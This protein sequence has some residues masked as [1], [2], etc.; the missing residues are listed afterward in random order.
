[1][2]G[3]PGGTGG[4]AA[5]TVEVP[6]LDDLSYTAL[7]YDDDF[8]IATIDAQW[9]LV[10]YAEGAIDSTARPSPSGL[11]STAT[12]P[13]ALL[14]QPRESTVAGLRLDA[15][16]ADGEAFLMSVWCSQP[17]RSD[18]SNNS[19]WIG[20][21]WGDSTTDPAALPNHRLCWDGG[22]QPRVWLLES[23]T[24]AVVTIDNATTVPGSLNQFLCSR[25][26]DV[27]RCWWRSDPLGA[28]VPM[29]FIDLAIE[30]TY[31]RTWILITSPAAFGGGQEL[32]AVHRVHSFKHLANASVPG[33]YL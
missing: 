22:D 5:A 28:W 14:L 3:Y 25:H 12:E 16:P 27:L 11:A 32:E 30:T 4:A 29:G 13:G 8:S 23:T 21:A 31:D 9:T 15:L 1:M 33:L 10:G 18:A 17:A 26:S 19:I 20:L 7:T 2:A 24:T 6:G